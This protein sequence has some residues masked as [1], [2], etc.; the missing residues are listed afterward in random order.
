VPLP[1][2]RLLLAILVP[3]TALMLVPIKIEVNGSFWDALMDA[4]HVPVFAF[5]TWLFFATNPAGLVRRRDALVA[6]ALLALGGAAGVE[7]LQ[8]YTGRNGNLPD[9]AHGMLGVTLAVSAIAAWSVLSTLLALV[10]AVVV[11]APPLAEA[12]AMAWRSRNF[13]LLGDFESDQELRLWFARDADHLV[14]RDTRSRVPAHATHG[15][16]SLRVPIRLTQ[17]PGVRLLCADQDWSSWR[18]LV[19]DL[20]NDGPPFTLALRIDDTHS[21]A[22]IDRFNAALPVRTGANTVRIPLPEVARA[23]DLRAVRRLVFYEL[24]PKAEHTYYLDYVRLE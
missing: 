5:V 18:T 9:F 20:Y 1:R 21:D 17:W 7:L 10:S 16:H 4:G 8:S 11:L 2:Y 15:T 6:A 14:S 12:R 22:Y 24:Q 13:P 23:I 3:L 19:F